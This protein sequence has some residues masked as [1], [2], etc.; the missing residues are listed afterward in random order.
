MNL[1]D[2]LVIDRNKQNGE[3]LFWIDEDTDCIVFSE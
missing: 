1:I 3:D 2:R